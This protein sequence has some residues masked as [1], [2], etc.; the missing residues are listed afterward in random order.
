MSFI[1]KRLSKGNKKKKYMFVPEEILNII[2]HYLNPH[3]FY[4]EELKYMIHDIYN[5]FE[6]FAPSGKD[7]GY[8]S[9]VMMLY[10]PKNYVIRNPVFASKRH[11]IKSLRER[12]KSRE[13]DYGLGK[14]IITNK[15]YLDY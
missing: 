11:K 4:L 8:G 12:F 3:E 14:S 10:S 2:Y 5:T 15:C 7:F 9:F 1:C 6:L 13:D